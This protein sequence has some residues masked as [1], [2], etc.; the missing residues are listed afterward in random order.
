METYYYDNEVEDLKK[1]KSKNRIAIQGVRGAFHEIATKKYF[2]NHPNLEIVE[3][4]T[5]DDL[6]DITSK[7]ELADGALM[8]IENTIAGS[9]MHNYNLLNDNDLQIS[10]EIYLRIV[11]NL[12]VHQNTKIEDIT[13]VYSHPVALAQCTAFFKNYPHVK[14]IEATDTALSVKMIKEKGLTHAGAI[15]SSLA[16]EIY[17]MEILAAS[18]ETYKRNYTRFLVLTQKKSF[19]FGE[20][21]DANKCSLVFSLKHEVGSLHT[22][23]AALAMFKAD[24]TKI[25]SAPIPDEPWH[26]RFFVDFTFDSYTHYELIMKAIRDLTESVKVLG[27]YQVGK[28]WET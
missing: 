5:F 13:E 26:Y 3:A 18:I 28:Y 23:L 15:A 6:I 14:L 19:S 24:L 11:Q 7:G 4:T 9:L 8:A 12:I 25:Q 27:V 10:G 21:S 16:A 20:S 1:T 22:V 17:G 2:G